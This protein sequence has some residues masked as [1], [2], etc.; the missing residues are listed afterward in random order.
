MQKRDIQTRLFRQQR[1]ECI[2]KSH[3]SFL[4]RAHLQ[5]CSTA[6]NSHTRYFQTWSDLC[7]LATCR[8]E[9]IQTRVTWP[10][11]EKSRISVLAIA[12][13]QTGSNSQQWYSWDYHS[14]SDL[15]WQEKFRQT[16]MHIRDNWHWMEISPVSSRKSTVSTILHWTHLAYLILR[17]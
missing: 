6:H 3:V 4:E 17:Y 7:R 2:R 15:Y 11:K 12:H 10:Y 16:S 1:S 14:R 8:Q 5:P 9:T 13:L